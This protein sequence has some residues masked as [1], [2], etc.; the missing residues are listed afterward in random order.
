MPANFLITEG[1]FNLGFPSPPPSSPS[2]SR[3]KTDGTQKGRL[4]ARPTRAHPRLLR[5]H[6]L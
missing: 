1:Y 6:N 4:P 3:N 5:S 2:R